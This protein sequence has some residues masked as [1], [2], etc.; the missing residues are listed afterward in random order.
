MRDQRFE[1]SAGNDELGVGADG[2]VGGDDI[3]LAA[4][5]AYDPAGQQP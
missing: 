2:S 5:D 4:V 1:G 3:A